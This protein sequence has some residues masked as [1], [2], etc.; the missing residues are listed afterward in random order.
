MN[1][2]ET[3]FFQDLIRSAASLNKI[4]VEKHKDVFKAER[5]FFEDL[6]TSTTHLSKIDLEKHTLIQHN[7]FINLIRQ[8]EKLFQ[9]ID[10]AIIDLTNSINKMSA[11]SIGEMNFK[12]QDIQQRKKLPRLKGKSQLQR[13][14]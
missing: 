2:A 7:F 5:E 12:V 3:V 6:I 14:K 4:D 10:S 9:K 13:K 11:D 1:K 8:N